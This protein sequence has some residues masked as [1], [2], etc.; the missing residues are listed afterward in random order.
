MGASGGTSIYATYYGVVKEVG[1][2]GDSN[3]GMG[4]Y[5]DINVSFTD[6]ETVTFTYMHMVEH[7]LRTWN[8]RGIGNYKSLIGEKV[9]PGDL[10]GRVGGTG[11]YD[12]HLHMDVRPLNANRNISANYKCVYFFAPIDPYCPFHPASPLGS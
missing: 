9:V 1:L 5:I 6:E 3:G 2:E 7:P 12:P 11:G 10:I 8:S 4:E